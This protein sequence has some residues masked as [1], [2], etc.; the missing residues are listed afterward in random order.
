MNDLSWEYM[1]SKLDMRMA[2]KCADDEIDEEEYEYYS[3][4]LQNLDLDGMREEYSKHFTL[5][6]EDE[7]DRAWM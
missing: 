3:D 1:Y 6:E 5:G 7:Y 2:D 4:M